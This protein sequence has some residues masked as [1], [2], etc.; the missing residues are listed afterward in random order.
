M[1]PKPLA[2]GFI[3]SGLHKIHYETYGNPKGNPWIFCHGGPGYHCVPKSNLKFFNLKKDYVILFDQRGAGK[4]RPSNYLKDNTTC[5]LIGDMNKILEKLNVDKVNILGGSWGSTLALT[6]AISYPE[7]VNSLVLRG[8][9][10]ARDEDVWAIYKP[11]KSWSENQKIKFDMTLGMLI[12]EFKIKN[13]LTDGL[14]ILKKRNKNS[15]EF[16]KKWAA[17]EDLIC[18]EVFSL[19]DFDKTYLKM[20]MDISIIEIHYFV[21]NCF[22][23]KN[24]ILNNVDKLKNIKVNIVQGAKDMVTPKNQALELANKLE[25]VELYLDPQ[26]GHSSNESM[27][28]VM[29]KMVSN[30]KKIK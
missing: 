21:N 24:Y 7:K 12:K 20:A 23:P 30:T 2:S 14:K 16:A 28:K 29:K 1:N 25:Q 19:I 18:S 6:Y 26:G 22:L 8:I 9:F 17:Y 4:S 13:I 5:H 27:T 11:L 10:L 15:L 3:K